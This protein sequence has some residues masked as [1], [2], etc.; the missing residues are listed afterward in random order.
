MSLKSFG[1]RFS[2]V[3]LLGQEFQVRASYVRAWA[4]FENPLPEDFPRS[5]GACFAMLFLP[6]FPL[7]S[8]FRCS[9]LPPCLGHCH[10]GSCPKL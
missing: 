7:V 2:L 10:T 6:F 4:V 1:L 5:G 9:F 8:S 3:P